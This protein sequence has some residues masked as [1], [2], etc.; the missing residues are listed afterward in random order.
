[1]GGFGNCGLK[2]C[3]GHLKRICLFVFTLVV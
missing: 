1:L 2:F 3:L